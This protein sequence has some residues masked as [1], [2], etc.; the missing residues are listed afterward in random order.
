MY[1]FQERKFLCFKAKRFDKIKKKVIGVKWMETIQI[2]KQILEQ[3]DRQLNFSY[4]LAG[5][6]VTLAVVVIGYQLIIN[7][8]K[9]K[10]IKR[11]NRKI[12][13]D[14]TA[15]IF[16]SNVKQLTRMGFYGI[17]DVEELVQIYRMNFSEDDKVTKQMS[18][19][20][21]RYIKKLLDQATRVIPFACYDDF[22]GKRN[23]EAMA[24]LAYAE[25]IIETYEHYS[26][27][28]KQQKIEELDDIRAEVRYIDVLF[29]NI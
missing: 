29:K 20:K 19:L 28:E 3:M 23:E 18:A 12:M 13:A 6:I 7:E 9:I 22:H 14:M 24:Q 15:P 2:S 5:T 25:K 4:F 11:E 1:E 27:S 16:I 10:E 26:E 17:R 8:K 21:S